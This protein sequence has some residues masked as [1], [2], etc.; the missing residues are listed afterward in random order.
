MRNVIGFCAFLAASAAIADQPWPRHAIET[1]LEGADGARLRDVNGDGRPDL[2]VGWEQSGVVALYLNPGPEKA[3]GPWPR[4]HFKGI[5]DVEDAVLVDLDGD[6]AMDVVSSCEGATRAIYVHWALKGDPMNPANWLVQPI[7]AAQGREQWMFCLPMQV[8]GKHGVDLV[9]GSKGKNASVSWLEAP[10]DPRNLAGWTLHRM[11]DA[12]WIMS[13]VAKDMDG[14][15]DEDVLIS[16][17]QGPFQGVRWLE[18]PG[19]ADGRRR[20]WTSHMVGGGGA[21][22]LFLDTADIDGDGLEDIVVARPKD[23]VA[24]RRLDRTGRNWEPHIIP[25]PE[26]VGTGKAVT[27]GDVDGDG[28]LDL[29]IGRAHV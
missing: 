19:D 9:V 14:D 13:I 21:Q 7:P 20:P 22:V 15:G 5:R 28:K 4:V 24:L 1:G 11:T 29:E 2:V 10:A 26:G 17:R 8:D 25:L 3:R 16:D 18:N 23:I 12:G 27:L 6:G